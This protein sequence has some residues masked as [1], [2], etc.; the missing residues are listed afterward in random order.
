VEP[1]GFVK[2]GEERRCLGRGELNELGTVLRLVVG[3]ERGVVAPKTDGG[4]VWRNESDSIQRDGRDLL[5][6]NVEFGEMKV[7]TEG[8]MQGGVARASPQKR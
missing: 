6:L 3:V 7:T 4:K 2:P 8:R 1:R 5:R